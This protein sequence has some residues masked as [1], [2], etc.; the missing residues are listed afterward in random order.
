M[1]NS[2]SS[3]FGIFTGFPC[4]LRDMT[5]ATLTL[6]V[7]KH[8][9]GYHFKGCFCNVWSSKPPNGLQAFNNASLNLQ[10]AALEFKNNLKGKTEKEERNNKN[11]FN[12]YLFSGIL[13]WS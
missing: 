9:T 8:D 12:V 3:P 7:E 13:S 4:L 5:E 11:C 10:W 6:H 2:T 1:T